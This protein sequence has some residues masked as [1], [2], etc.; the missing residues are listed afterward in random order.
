MSLSR[1]TTL[2]WLAGLPAQAAAANKALTV[3][4]SVSFRKEELINVND[5]GVSA[6]LADNGPALMQLRDVLIGIDRHRH[7]H[8]YFPPNPLPYKYSINRWLM[9]LTSF[10]LEG[11]GATLQC[12][13]DKQ[14]NSYD[15]M[16]FPQHSSI[17]MNKGDQPGQGGMS[18]HTGESI[19]APNKGD[20]FINFHDP[21]QIGTQGY[22]VGGWVLVHAFNQQ[23]DDTF[24]S[25]YPPNLRYF[26]F[27]KIT[28]IKGNTIKLDR[29]LL[30][31][32]RKDYP[33]FIFDDSPIASIGQSEIQKFGKPRIINL[34][35]RPQGIGAL[36]YPEYV[37]VSG[38]NIVSNPS[39]P[40]KYTVYTLNGIHTIIEDLTILDGES[41]MWLREGRISRVNRVKIKTAFEPD[42]ILDRLAM[43]DCEAYASAPP[44]FGIRSGTGVNHIE[45]NSVHVDGIISVVAQ[46][47]LKIKGGS[48]S[49][50][51]T[52]LRNFV[53]N[54][55][56]EFYGGVFGGEKA[57][58]SDLQFKKKSRQSS[59]LMGLRTH[60]YYPYRV[61]AV[62]EQAI[63][64]D[65]VM[66]LTTT[67]ILDTFI[68]IVRPGFQILESNETTVIGTVSHIIEGF[69]NTIEVHLNVAGKMPSNKDIVKVASIQDVSI[70]S[71]S[72]IKPI[73]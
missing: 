16:P 17:F 55:P 31:P 68:R 66:P 36:Y 65:R 45:L 23:Y 6:S 46:K 19:A 53:S 60:R 56:F 73:Q 58:I 67:E 14:W 3:D 43:S 44:H 50:L 1:R 18:F 26:E 47:T 37:R 20:N 71:E 62:R 10:H 25:G 54:A 41:Y 15:S 4:Q 24:G 64:I 48:A 13:W 40:D 32:Y 12:T 38:L 5:Y 70:D 49:T 27:C 69:D 30:E 7:W 8:F 63:I 57:E 52:S 35:G 34:S 9:G 28:A 2:A 11:Y 21:A 39:Y 42:K 22:R 61:T 72:F 59:I 51:N 33:E 29:L